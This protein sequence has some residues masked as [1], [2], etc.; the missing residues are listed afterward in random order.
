MFLLVLS[1]LNSKFDGTRTLYQWN[2]G[3]VPP[4]A[5][6]VLERRNGRRRLRGDDGDD[7]DD[8]DEI[9]VK[10]ANILTST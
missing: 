2:S 7:D 10:H 9:P 6:M 1:S 4:D 8:R 5:V 3:G